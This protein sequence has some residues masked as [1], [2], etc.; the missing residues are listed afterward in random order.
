MEVIPPRN[1]AAC[2]S[3]LWLIAFSR[4]GAWRPVRRWSSVLDL[5]EAVLGPVGV[6]EGE[7]VVEADAEGAGEG[8]GVLVD[9]E[10]ELEGVVAR[11]EGGVGLC[12]IIKVRRGRGGGVPVGD[13]G[14]EGGVHAGL[15][16]PFPCVRPASGGRRRST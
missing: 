15:P 2:R 5:G 9:R 14:F 8:Q 12:E 4:P 11:V 6:E 7:E 16:L 13:G 1:C 3:K 10:D